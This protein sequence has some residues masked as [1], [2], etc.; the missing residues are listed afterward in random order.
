VSGGKHI[1]SS[2][3][4]EAANRLRVV[5]NL[6]LRAESRIQMIRGVQ[7]HCPD[8]VHSDASRV[9]FAVGDAKLV[10]SVVAGGAAVAV[11]PVVIAAWVGWTKVLTAPLPEP[12]TVWLGPEVTPTNRTDPINAQP[13]TAASNFV[14]AHSFIAFVLTLKRRS[15]V[16]SPSEAQRRAGASARRSS[17]QILCL[18][19]GRDS[20]M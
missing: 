12:A 14:V 2:D 19:Y 18:Q 7:G 16:I 13:P 17:P 9:A 4:L 5:V 15:L 20:W 11:A 1:E 8:W 10:A 3:E 6:G